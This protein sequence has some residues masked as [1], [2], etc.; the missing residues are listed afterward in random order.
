MKIF[1]TLGPGCILM[2]VAMQINMVSD[3]RKPVLRIFD[4]DSNQSPQLQRL[5]RILNFHTEQIL[6]LYFSDSYSE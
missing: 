4:K 3:T 2:S 1:I 5:A 6:L